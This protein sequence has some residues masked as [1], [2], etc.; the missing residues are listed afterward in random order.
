MTIFDYIM[1]AFGYVSIT[2][3][4][5][6]KAEKHQ[7]KEDNDR[8]KTLLRQAAVRK[9]GEYREHL[10]GK[11]EVVIDGMFIHKSYKHEDAFLI[12]YPSLKS[13]LI[14]DHLWVRGE[15]VGDISE[16]DFARITGTV[17]KYHSPNY[18]RKE[19]YGVKD[20][21]IERIG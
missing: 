15:I 17:Y 14:A 8:L 7:T 1:G 11:G 10:K 5:K 16:G 21:V 3:I 18:E 12:R 6:C 9:T 20:S 4:R 13:K 19:N 2:N